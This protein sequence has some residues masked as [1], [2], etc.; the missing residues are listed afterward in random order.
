MEQ[1][2]SSAR[3]TD[4]ILVRPDQHDTRQNTPPSAVAAALPLR[5]KSIKKPRK[6][7]P[8]EKKERD[9]LRMK[10]QSQRR[11]QAI[12]DQY[13]Q[14][15]RF[16]QEKI[17]RSSWHQQER[18]EEELVLRRLERDVV[19]PQRCHPAAAGYYFDDAA[20]KFTI[21]SPVF[22][23]Y[24]HALCPPSQASR[25][26]LQSRS[27]LQRTTNLPA[28]AEYLHPSCHGYAMAKHDDSRCISPVF[29]FAGFA[30]IPL[31]KIALKQ[32]D[33]DDS[34]LEDQDVGIKLFDEMD[35]G[36][37]LSEASKTRQQETKR[38]LE[39]AIAAREFYSK[40][41]GVA[42]KNCK[43]PMCLVCKKATVTAGCPG[44]FSFSSKKFL[45]VE[46]SKVT[47][48]L[49]TPK[50]S[51]QEEED[52]RARHKA[53]QRQIIMPPLL[54]SLHPDA[55]PS[56]ITPHENENN[57]YLTVLP[58]FQ[59][60]RK[61]RSLSNKF[62]TLHIKS[63]PVGQ[64][65]SLT[66]D[67]KSSVS[68]LYELY[69]ANTELPNRP[70]HLLLPTTHG[71]F[72]LN[73]HI[74]S[75]TYTRNGVVNGELLLQDFNLQKS[76][77]RS[78]RVDAAGDSK[79][80]QFLLFAVAILH[81]QSTPQLVLN[82]VQ[83]NFH[84][85]PPESRAPSPLV[86][87]VDSKD[88]SGLPQWSRLVPA[89]FLLPKAVDQDPFQIQIR[90]HIH[91]MHVF[92]K[93]NY[94]I[95]AA[96]QREERERLLLLAHQEAKAAKLAL[97]KNL[98]DQQTPTVSIKVRR[99][100]A[101]FEFIYE[102][103]S[104]PRQSRVA[105]ERLGKLWQFVQMLE[106]WKILKGG[107]LLDIERSDVTMSLMQQLKE[108]ASVAF[109]QMMFGSKTD[110]A[111]GTLPYPVLCL[112]GSGTTRKLVLRLGSRMGVTPQNDHDYGMVLDL[113][114]DFEA[115]ER[116]EPKR[117]YMKRVSDQGEHMVVDWYDAEWRNK[118][119]SSSTMALLVSSSDLLS[120]PFYRIKW[121]LIVKAYKLV[122]KKVALVSS[123]LDEFNCLARV[124]QTTDAV[125]SKAQ[126][127]QWQA[128]VDHFLA[129]IH[130][131][132]A[133]A[134]AVQRVLCKK[135][136]AVLKRRAQARRKQL[137]DREKE[138]ERLRELQLERDRPKLTL[139]QQLKVAFM[140]ERAPKMREAVELTPAEKLGA[141]AGEF[142]GKAASG[143]AKAARQ[144]KKEYAV[145]TL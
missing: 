138:L 112:E 31:D 72:Y 96:E 40:S 144:A 80:S 4:S 92:A 83:Q 106:E 41:L 114:Q 50:T 75:A 104:N 30:K 137:R 64:L 98:R 69:R 33:S 119:R 63:L 88:S 127:A 68:Y 116:E 77:P 53:L 29:F 130:E 45:E 97:K 136:V 125:L 143:V 126:L 49:K 17:S 13:D 51:F 18:L 35:G 5:L 61:Y 102:S 28:E 20:Q 71:L 87:S 82:Y 57:F 118:G 74:A 47:Q 86:I 95:V 19:E 115:L 105:E 56:H 36:L 131:N 8:L 38:R 117:G 16:A 108:T 1:V 73:E 79:N 54:P 39:A 23:S 37:E 134:R 15:K 14:A 58:D 34:D 81:P 113:D 90:P 122:V 133:L 9:R 43:A 103:T 60:I 93:T 109:N 2:R 121:P 120:P 89:T 62:I 7:T 145:R 128:D 129:T 48:R 25:F 26:Q 12:K 11:K 111:G 59:A 55:D 141:K 24:S 124:L 70:L 94:A 67:L 21:S 6:L 91:A 46:A 100:L 52:V 99:A 84:F 107:R 135:G 66:V 78:D 27:G 85:K 3:S 110:K 139:A 32:D 65:I 101:Y 123:K 76:I 132:C 10:E 142:L 44:C 140:K 22:A 42:V